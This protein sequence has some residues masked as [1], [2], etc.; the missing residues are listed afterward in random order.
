MLASGDRCTTSPAIPFAV[1]P[2]T[3]VPAALPAPGR[4]VLFVDNGLADYR[5]IVRAASPGASVILLD[6]HQDALTQIADALAGCRGLETVAIVSHGRPGALLAGNAALTRANMAQYQARLRAIGAALRPGGALD[7]YGCDIGAGSAG[8]AFIAALARRTGAVVAASINP[9]GASALGGDWDL[10]IATGATASTPALEAQHLRSYG[11]LLGDTTIT[12]YTD[13]GITLSTPVT[14]IA[15]GATIQTS[16]NA[17]YAQVAATVLNQGTIS[18]YDGIYFAAVGMVVNSAYIAGTGTNDG[19]NLGYGI[20]LSD[21]GSV[22]NQFGGTITGVGRGVAVRSS[23]GAVI[24]DGTIAGSTFIGVH[25]QSGGSVINQ[26]DGTIIG[27]NTGIFSE[28]ASADVVNSGNITGSNQYGVYLYTGGSVTNQSAGTITGGN[29]GVEIQNVAGTV[30]NS[31]NIAGTSFYGVHLAAGGSVTNQSAGTITGG[32]DGV[33]IAGDTGTVINSGSII[34]TSWHGILLEF[35]G[36]VTNQSGGYIYGP[37]SG[38]YT[39]ASFTATVANFGTIRAGGG[40]GVDVWGGG[41]VSNA[42]SGLITGSNAGV[43]IITTDASVTNAGTIRGIQYGVQFLVA[44]G[45]VTNASGGYIYSQIDDGIQGLGGRNPDTVINAG[46]ITSH[47]LVGIYIDAA[48]YVSNASTG[49]ITGGLAGIQLSNAVGTVV[50]AGTVSGSVW[51]GVDLRFG[52]TV[53][54]AATGHILGASSAVLVENAPGTVINAGSIVDSASAGINLL[55]G[56]Y[57]SN[58]SSGYVSGAQHGVEIQ[59]ATGT[60]VN[61]GNITGTNVYG[62]Y[63]ADGGFVTNQSVGTITGGS[64][65]VRVDGGLGTVVNSGSI[66]GSSHHGIL[67]QGGGYVSNASSGS[68]HGGGNGIYFNATGYGTV[69]NAG[70]VTAIGAGIGFNE[71]GRV[72]NASS[73]NIYGWFKGIFLNSG[74]GGYVSNSS[75]GRIS[76]RYEQGIFFNDEAGTVVNAGTI[77]GGTRSGV[78][79][80]AVQFAAGHANRLI[81]DP[82]AVFNGVVD[83]GNTIGSTVFS[84]LELAAGT[85]T[86]SGLGSH[87]IDFARTTIDAGASWHLTGSNNTLAA[88]STLTNSGTLTLDNATLTGGATLVNN[89]RIVLD[90][91]SMTVATLNGTG[92]VEIDADSTLTVTG[93]IA[94]S[95]TIVFNGAHAVLAVGDPAGLAAASAATLSGFAPGDSIDLTAIGFTAGDTAYMSGTTLMVA[96][97]NGTVT[98]AFNTSNIDANSTFTVG[99]DGNGKELVSFTPYYITS[100]KTGA[101]VFINSSATS[102]WLISATSDFLLGGGELAIKKDSPTV[103]VVFSVYEGNSASGS[104]VASVAVPD[105]SVTGTFSTVLFALPGGGYTLLAGHTYFIT[106][107]STAAKDN[108]YF[109]KNSAALPLFDSTG[110]NAL[111]A[112]YYSTS[113]GVSLLLGT[114]TGSSSTDGITSNDALTGDASAN[115]V[116]T[117]KDGTTVLGTVTADATGS[118]SF[119]P[120]S[121]AQGTHTIVAS[122]SGGSASLAFT[123]DTVAP[124]V[125]VGLGTDGG[126]SNS[127]HITNVDTLTGS[128]DVNA[129][130]TLTE[131]TTILGTATADANGT[132]SFTQTSL[133][134]G[135]HTV[136][137]SETDVAGNVGTHSL[138]FTYDTVNPPVTEVLG[139]DSGISDSDHITNVDTLTGSGDANAVVTLTDG[140]TILGTATA[141]GSGTWSFTPTSLAQGTHTVVASETDTAGNIGTASLTFTYD[142]VAASVTEALGTDSGSSNSDRITNVDT[143]TGSGDANAVVTLTEGTAILGTATANGSGTWSFTPTSLA[144][145]TH[146]VVASETDTAGN[147]GTASL[148]FTYDTVA[149]SVTEA[150]GTDSGSSNSDRITNV[151]TLTGSGDANA[152]VTLTE[153]TTILGT[154]TADANGTWSF[155]PTSL[156]QGTHTVL[157]SETDAAG[158]IGTAS[159]TFTYDTVAASVTEALGTDSGSSNSDRITNVDTLTG[160]GDANAVVTLTEGTTIL[161]T[162][163]A[164]ANGTW[165]FTPTSLAQ[166][167]HTVLASETDAAG[168]IGTASLTFTYDTVAASVTEALGTDSGIYNNDQLTNIDK[169][170]GSGDANAVV[171]LTDGTTILGTTT[172]DANGK[173]TFTPSSLAQG[174]H[175]VVASET[176]IA[177]NVGTGTLTFTYDTV[178]PLAT[179]ALG[180]DTGLSSDKITSND[181]LTGTGTPNE[182]L[183]LM[184]GSVLLGLATVNALGSWSLTPTW[185]LSQGTHTISVGDLAGNVGTASLTFTYDTIAPHVTLFLTNNPE[186]SSTESESATNYA[187]DD[188]YVRQDA[189]SGTGDPSGIVTLKDGTTTLGIATV[190]AGGSWTFTPTSLSQGLHM[191]VASE[192]DVAGNVGVSSGGVFFV[193][194]TQAPTVTEGLGTDTGTSSSDKITS[195]DTLTG[196]GDAASIA[197]VMG[198]R[199]VMANAIV[200]LTEGTAVLGT[201]TANAAGSWSFTPAALAQGTHTIIAS[202]TDYAGNVGTASVSFTYDSL[203]PAV[204][205]AL[206]TDTGRSSTDRI[207]SSGTLTGGGDPGAVVTLK[208]GTSVIGT[209]TANGAGT[210]SFVPSSLAQGTHTIVASET[211]TAGNVG[212]ASLAFT[213]DTAAAIVTERLSSDTGAS[214]SDKITANAAL[215]GSGD[216]GATVTLTEG[217]RVLG[218]ALANGAGTWSFAPASLAQGTH[219]IVASETD[220]AGNVGTSPLTFTYD[221]V[222]PGVTELLGTDT[223]TPGDYITSVGTLTGSGDVGAVVTLREGGNVIG[224]A[225]ANG[226][227]TWSFMPTP[228]S[229]GLHTIVASE[230]DAAGNV[231]AASLRFTYDSIAPAV[232]AALVS[233]TGASAIDGITSN[234][235]ITGKGDLYAVVT[236]KEGSSV[237][238][239]AKAD[240]SGRWVFTPTSL[241]Q[242]TH[243][244]VASETDAAGNVGTANPVGF[245]YDTIAPAVT[246]VLGTVSHTAIAMLTGSGDANAVVTLMDGRSSIGSATAIAS[247]TWSFT[248]TS[249]ATG[250]HAIVAM[251]TDAAG[252]VGSSSLIDIVVGDAG[253]NTINL[254]TLGI[255]ATTPTF[256]YGLGGTDTISGGGMTSQLWF[257]GGAGADTMTG[258]SG[259]NT[260]LYGAAS[261]STPSAMD[262]ITN[263]NAGKDLI[264]LTGLG[265]ALASAGALSGSLAA[266]SM[267]WQAGGGNTFVYVNTSGSSE[268]LASTD[269]KIELLGTPVLTSANF[270]LP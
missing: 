12:G 251:E 59:S 205:E 54:N 252:N 186:E 220:I 236:L 37:N 75:G 69:I 191:I 152:V 103:P 124:G 164:D 45:S 80:D 39:Q 7:L 253:A 128:G 13:F 58:A 131:G 56:G 100:G 111:S 217:T 162:A 116:I 114:D 228:L 226:A 8:R 11:H 117:I 76:A 190:N 85:G 243:T 223:G 138:T 153:G 218:S 242:G 6:R 184:E 93:T 41:Y 180:T 23:P 43:Q 77:S 145:G 240:S 122:D 108:G 126:S 9:T 68:V 123:Y 229:Q 105:T 168:N 246:E 160:S 119:T 88:G 198:T 112:S 197:S 50:N 135:T 98:A 61:S 101:Q 185:P 221:T 74:G 157:A 235:Q 87:Y 156:A 267:G 179:V 89:S 136:V 40:Q 158:N 30:V 255:A 225:T 102:S 73:G 212:T 204:T 232:T 17:V 140:T 230:T 104:P 2:G 46:T 196:T 233:D 163:T 86:I 241:A 27:F 213:Y 244:I 121:L 249:L 210:W 172:A 188:D 51:G 64:Y 214:A 224:T 44:S 207:T 147:I 219:T 247:G 258:G 33:K 165:S 95:E 130:V 256:I 110:T 92:T 120:T 222:A 52:G 1:A 25:L 161:G 99:T 4:K 113:G 53:S 15:A 26:S 47:G 245:T 137:A 200:R 262:I 183:A 66:T 127:D 264:D 254:R 125:T 81:I 82:G 166:G 266:H 227:G 234:G 109:I 195:N 177:G 169:L 175:T 106:V 231:G 189:L 211:D 155:T 263:F 67:L 19:G 42:S 170:T 24:N 60:V 57:V 133:A 10:Q 268:A 107:S 173:W 118:W 21:G 36:Q 193:Y 65:G 148:T 72:V 84:T 203:A 28:T 22:T 201:T 181:A 18:G 78:D 178:P 150:L 96:H 38:V 5:Q 171:T 34:G 270:L 159:L 3:A 260:Y 176:D 142:T 238:G 35:G 31:G 237:L 94:A 257:V 16:R 167:T 139:T 29:F 32:N 149:A 239:T 248:P 129:I 269:M 97:S 154:A 20:L 199:I 14:T 79:G 143:L 144:Q 134:Q 215:T 202:E 206:G 115:A 265:G 194:D 182:V 250:A 192:T 48:A 49:T 146:T 83:G 55:S 71:N 261:E 174:T 151:D 259:I 132:W 208:E 62:V 90:P 63:L 216:A 70:S 91:S 141:N 187:S 209:A